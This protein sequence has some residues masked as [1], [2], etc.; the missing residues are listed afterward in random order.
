[1]KKHL[2]EM[3]VT[4]NEAEFGNLTRI[5]DP[6]DKGFL[7]FNTFAQ[8]FTP[9]M[10]KTLVKENDDEET[11]LFKRD[12]QN[13][14]PN[15]EKI[16]ENRKFNQTFGE[17]FNNIRQTLLPDKNMLL[18]NYLFRKKYIDLKP[19]TRFGATP[20]HQDTFYNVQPPTTSGMYCGENVLIFI[21][22]YIY[23]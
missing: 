19:S 16:Q 18:S 8:T 20:G 5:L 17:R 22:I 21:Y 7:D 15:R 9:L 14:C 6:Q 2:K 10:S 13:L 4:L 12:R 23:I 3:K 11:F 1:M